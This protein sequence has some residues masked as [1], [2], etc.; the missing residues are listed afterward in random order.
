[1]KTIATLL[2]D[3]LLLGALTLLASVETG[4]AGPAVHRPSSAIRHATVPIQLRLSNVRD[5]TFTV[6]WL[7]GFRETGHL[8]YGREPDALDR[9]AYD[10]RGT[11]YQGYTHYV[12]VSE[13][14]PQ[15]TYYYDVISG[16]T[17][18]N[19]D[20]AHYQVTTGPDLAIPAPYLVFGQVLRADG[21]QAAGSLVYLTLQDNDGR[22]TPGESALL[23]ALVDQDGYWSQ[24]LSNARSRDLR[25]LFVFSP[26]T[27][28]LQ[29]EAEGGPDG[30]ASRTVR[31]GDPIQ[32]NPLLT[33]TLPGGAWPTPIP[34]TPPAAT[35]TATPTVTP[36]PPE[37]TSTPTNT[38]VLQ[39]TPTP[40]STSAVELPTPTSTGVQSNTPTPTSTGA[41]ESPTPTSTGVQSNTPTPGTPGQSPAPT[42]TFAGQEAPTSTASP[43]AVVTL[44]RP[45]PSAAVPSNTPTV[46]ATSTRTAMV[47]REAAGKTSTPSPSPWESE[48]PAPTSPSWAG[49]LLLVAGA[50]LILAAIVLFWRLGKENHQSEEQ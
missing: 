8:R 17:T 12:V 48:R 38:V 31:P 3:L 49:W 39:H 24:S 14:Q 47:T 23:S 42:V 13:L 33:I 21:R 19:N 22:G 34:T 10:L 20:G 16:G 29:I 2:F 1:M 37:P 25:D 43:T 40:A 41:V 15:T 32:G 46:Q 28:Q 30:A 11:S 27:D 44:A 7:T 18:D 4:L 45:S 9:T 6:S 26:T 35:A 5:T 36:Q 50:I